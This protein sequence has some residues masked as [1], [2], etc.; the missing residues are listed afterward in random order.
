MITGICFLLSLIC[1]YLVSQSDPGVILPVK[2]TRRTRGRRRKKK[3]DINGEQGPSAYTSAT[4]GT[5]STDMDIIIKVGEGEGEGEEEV[6]E[7][8]EEVVEE[9]EEDVIDPIVAALERGEAVLPQ[10]LVEWKLDA[11]G[12]WYVYL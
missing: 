12:N 6:E 11:F 4:T 9:V 2:T 1:L 8:E 10:P 5:T 7:V 3:R